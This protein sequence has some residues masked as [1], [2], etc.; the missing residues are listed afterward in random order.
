M[1]LA[2]GPGRWPWQLALAD[3][4][5]SSQLALAAAQLTLAAAQLALAAAQLALA[6]AQLALTASQLALAAAQLALAEAQLALAA[7]QLALAA[8]QT[9]SDSRTAQYGLLY[10]IISYFMSYYSQNSLILSK[11]FIYYVQYSYKRGS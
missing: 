3:G 7:A 2:A 5:G 11:I 8:V 4:P 10:T 1:A 6:A 9:R